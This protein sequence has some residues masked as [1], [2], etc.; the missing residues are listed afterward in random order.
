MD[1]PYWV[2]YPL[3]WGIRVSQT[4]RGKGVSQILSPFSKRCDTEFVDKR[5]LRV[6]LGQFE[7]CP[8]RLKSISVITDLHKLG[9][10]WMSDVKK[11]PWPV[12]FL[13]N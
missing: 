1:L 4:P 8:R 10:K 6:T 3:P 12:E 2:H 13:R 5:D 9:G 11:L 7:N